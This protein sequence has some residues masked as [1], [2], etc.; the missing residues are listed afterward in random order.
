METKPK[1]RIVKRILF[2]VA[3]LLL[4]LV[5]AGASAII[6]YQ[7]NISAIYDV[8]C[9]TDECKPQEFVVKEGEGA[10]RIGENLEKAGLIKSSFAFNLYLKFQAS[11]KNLLPGKYQ[12]AKSMS[13]EQ[14]VKS[15]N[16]GIVKPTVTVTFYPG[17]TING[18]QNVP[19]VRS[20][21]IAAGF[22]EAEVD[23]ALTKEYS[24]E[25]LSTK[26]QGASLE[27]YIWADTYQFYA[28]ESVENIIT[29]LLDHM[30]KV[31][32]E[33]NLIAKFQERGLTLHEGIT[34]ASVIQKESPASYNEKRHIAQVFELRL[35]KGIPLG[36]D[37]II[38]YEA[39]QINPG[40]NRSDMSYLNTIGCP[41]NSRRCQ[42]L[43]P[44][45]IASPNRES[46]KA[47]TEPTDTD[48]LYFLADDQGNMYYAKTKAG[49]QDNIK[50]YCG[51]VCKI[52]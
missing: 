2:I 31:V 44:T 16:E 10:Q 39:D 20:R 30:L 13:V 29:S 27:G 6:W 7:S 1:K 18:A 22:K 52:L 46:L 17:E 38:A 23:A 3:I 25:L 41:W 28:D 21:L 32:K 47:V 36:S 5:I 15:L 35:K 12:F 26:P 34:L 24:H 50:K 8:K 45:P 37:A 33:E 49:H 11:N 48:D 40:R 14:I 9:S 42:G 51:E 43:P 19:G 4:L